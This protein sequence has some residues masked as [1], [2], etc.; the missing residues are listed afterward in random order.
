MHPAWSDLG[1]IYRLA[2][3]AEAVI[4][5]VGANTRPR[6]LF[7]HLQPRHPKAQAD[8]ALMAAEVRLG[9]AIRNRSRIKPGTDGGH[10]HE[11]DDRDPSLA[12]A[13]DEEEEQHYERC[14]RRDPAATG[15]SS[16]DAGQ[17]N[18][19]GISQE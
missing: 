19:R 14:G 1:F 12:F 9:G 3:L 7:P 13:P 8:V 11:H 5:M 17:R 16:R 6:S 4:E 2:V 15:L 10:Y 18:Q